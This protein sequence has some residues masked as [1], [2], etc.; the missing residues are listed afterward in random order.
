MN[1]HCHHIL[2]ITGGGGQLHGWQGSAVMELSVCCVF[3]SVLKTIR[4]HPQWCG[5][6]TCST[7][8]SMHRNLLGHLPPEKEKKKREKKSTTFS[9][10]VLFFL[11][12]V[13]WD[14]VLRALRLLNFQPENN[15]CEFCVC[16]SSPALVP[17]LPDMPIC[18]HSLQTSTTALCSVWASAVSL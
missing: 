11:Y 6:Y 17:N 12:L 15:Y 8:A 18:D 16:H 2:V 4:E 10:F 13:M 7:L 14:M 5:R 1:H 3:N 9:P